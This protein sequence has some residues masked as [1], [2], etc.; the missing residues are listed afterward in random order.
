MPEPIVP[1]DAQER[2][3]VAVTEGPLAPY[4]LDTVTGNKALYLTDDGA[5]KGA[6][7]LEAGEIEMANLGVVDGE[8]SA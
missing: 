2:R 3:F 1:T 4:V 7:Y 8:V 6:E 5:H